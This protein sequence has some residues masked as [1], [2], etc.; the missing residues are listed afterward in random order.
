MYIC[1]C[2]NGTNICKVIIGISNQDA[3]A[4]NI[5]IFA[6]ELLFLWETHFW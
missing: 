5:P 6:T 3:A 4:F 2:I 1:F